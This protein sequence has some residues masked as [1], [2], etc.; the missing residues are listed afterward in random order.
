[1]NVTNVNDN[2][3]SISSSTFSADENQTAIGTVTAADADGDTISFGISGSDITIDSSSGVIAF[4]SAPNYE[5]I[6]S[7]S[8]VVSASDGTN[9]STQEITVNIND[10]NDAP[11]A[12]SKAY[13]TSKH[14]LKQQ[15]H[16]RQV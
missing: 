10:V 11:V 8:V 4:R 6:N 14:N 2:S 3:P 13:W 5:S 9:T 12:T 1:M 16:G 7:Y 15:Q